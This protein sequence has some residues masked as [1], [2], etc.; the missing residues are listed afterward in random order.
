MA[1]TEQE[2]HIIVKVLS[3][4]LSWILSSFYA[5]PRFAE[6]KLLW[7]NLAKISSLHNLA[8]TMLDDFNKVLSS[9]DKCGGNPDN[10]RRAQIFKDC[11]DGTI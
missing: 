6:C 4:N 3:S 7:E 5:S 2:I 8:W 1:K 9:A 10:I 11:L